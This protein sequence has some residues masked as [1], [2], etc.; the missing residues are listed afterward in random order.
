MNKISQRTLRDLHATLPEGTECYL[1]EAVRSALIKYRKGAESS[2]F[3]DR[4]QAVPMLATRL[5]RG[6]KRFL[7]SEVQLKL[8]RN[9]WSWSH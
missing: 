7:K 9:T 4:D 8:Q 1:C 6:L 2:K 5:G 3:I